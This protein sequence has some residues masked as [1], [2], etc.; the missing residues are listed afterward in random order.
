[1][2]QNNNKTKPPNG[3][4]AMKEQNQKREKETN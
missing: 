2:K 3:E 1:M 4:V